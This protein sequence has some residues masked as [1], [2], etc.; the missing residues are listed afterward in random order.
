MKRGRKKGIKN[1]KLVGGKK[2]NVH[3]LRLKPE[4]IDYIRRLERS[5]NRKVKQYQEDYK[6]DEQATYIKNKRHPYAP[7]TEYTNIQS[8]KTRMRLY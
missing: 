7:R 3:G 5:I 1:L 2:V 6:I 8:I 4:E